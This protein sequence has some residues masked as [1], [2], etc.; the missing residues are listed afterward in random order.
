MSSMSSTASRG[1]LKAMKKLQEPRKRYQPSLDPKNI[2]SPEKWLIVRGDLVQMVTGADKNKQGVVREVIRKE[3]RLIVEGLNVQ[4][5]TLPERDGQ[6][7]RVVSRPQPVH[8]SAVALVCPETGRP[9]R[10]ARRYLEDGTRVRVAALSGAIIPRP[11][12]LLQRRRAK[13]L[14]VGPKDTEAEAAHAVTF[15]GVDELGNEIQ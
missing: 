2:L 8:V 3:N 4:Q 10:A 12:V 13:N 9:T 6:A 5:V 15:K 11:E 1:L 7:E 14:I